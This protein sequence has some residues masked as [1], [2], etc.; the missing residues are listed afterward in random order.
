MRIEDKIIFNEIK[1]GNKEVYKALF[2]DYYEHLVTFAK[3]F[4][5]DQQESENLVQDLFVFL[6]ENASKVKIET[7]VK[8]YFYQAVRNRCLNYIKGLKVRD[9]NHLMYMDGMLQTDDEVEYF[10]PQIMVDIKTSINELP[11]Q[12]AKVFTMKMIDGE[13]RESIAQ[14]LGVSVNTVKTQLQRAKKKLREKL[15]DKTN[16]LFFL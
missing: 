4:L 2:D 16:L 9:K 5:F 6:W 15:L 14:E 7:S 1:Q 10:D 12:M 8:A 3:S 13:T 11:E